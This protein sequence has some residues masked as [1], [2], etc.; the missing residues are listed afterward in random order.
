MLFR[1]VIIITGSGRSGTTILG[2]IIGSMEPCYYLFEPSIM[3]YCADVDTLRPVL[4]EDYWVLQAQ[5][6]NLNINENEDSYYLNYMDNNFYS[7]RKDALR[8]CQE[9]KLCIKVTEYTQDSSTVKSWFPGL[10]FIHIYRNGNDVVDSMAIRGWFTNPYME[11][12]YLD[13]TYN[14]G[15]PWFIYGME[16][17][18]WCTYNQHTRCAAVWRSTTE[19]GIDSDM[20]QI[21]Y[22]NLKAYDFDALSSDLGLR[23]SKLTRKH[24]GSIRKPVKHYDITRNIQEP[25]KSRFMALMNRLEYV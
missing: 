19:T 24:I 23:I 17:G 11:N 6:R 1:S 14:G 2:K 12:G 10:K 7:K 22:E 8:R 4:F 25:E 9:S 16:A 18:E 13:A 20:I 15:V 3:K 5:G 21:K